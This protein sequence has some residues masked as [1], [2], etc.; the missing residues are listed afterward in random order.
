M[1]GEKRTALIAGASGL[2][3]VALVDLL[4]ASETFESVHT[5]VRK[6]GGNEDARLFEHVIRF[7]ELD[8]LRLGEVITDAFCCLGT[9]MR[10]AGSKDAFAAVDRDYVSRFAALARRS[11]CDRFAVI[12]AVGASRGSAFFYSRVKGQMEEDLRKIGFRKLAIIRPSL[13]LGQ[14]R[15]FRLGEA[16]SAPFAVALRPVLSGGLRKYRPVSAAD[17]ASSMLDALNDPR[18]GVNVIYPT[19]RQR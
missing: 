9:T 19:E 8:K 15:E 3:G 14:R 16:V 13:L 2:V 17:V 5:L 12:S 11:G 7:D 10:A 6:R 1:K 4:L 18:P